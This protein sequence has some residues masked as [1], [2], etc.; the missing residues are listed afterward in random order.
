MIIADANVNNTELSHVRVDSRL[1]LR[2]LGRFVA[3]VP[4]RELV[5]QTPVSG[6]TGY[7]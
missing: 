1:K 7:F 6:A 4:G 3:S 2:E 5:M